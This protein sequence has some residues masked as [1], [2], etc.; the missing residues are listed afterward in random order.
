MPA[1]VLVAALLLAACG[2]QPADP[3]VVT[4]DEDRQLNEAAAAL[5]ANT[6]AADDPQDNAQ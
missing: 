3:S 6:V 2:Q 5:D 4:S 1:R